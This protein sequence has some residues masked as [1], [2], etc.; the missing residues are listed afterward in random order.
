[1]FTVLLRRKVSMYVCM[2]VYVCTYIH[3]MFFI[4]KTNY[5]CLKIFLFFLVTRLVYY[6]FFMLA[7][8]LPYESYK[9][10]VNKT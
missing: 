5:I 7:C 1:M 2:Y 9:C 6:D 4:I 3:N 10:V 8:F